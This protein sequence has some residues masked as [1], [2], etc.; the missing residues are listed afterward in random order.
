MAWVALCP[1]PPFAGSGAASATATPRRPIA[2]AVEQIVQAGQVHRGSLDIRQVVIPKAQLEGPVGSVND[3]RIATEPAVEK[4]WTDRTKPHAEGRW[5]FRSTG[6]SRSRKARGW[7]A[8]ERASDDWGKIWPSLRD[9][10]LFRGESH[11]RPTLKRIKCQA[12]GGDAR[13]ANSFT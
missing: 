7:M 5:Q 12:P 11:K 13:M 2:D 4:R 8:H 9:P 6:W 1:S 3:P 10:P